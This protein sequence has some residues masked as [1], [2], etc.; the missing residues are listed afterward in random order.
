MSDVSG[1]M[2]PLHA[3]KDPIRCPDQ[4]VYC[5]APK[6]REVAF[7]VNKAIMRVAEG[8]SAN[9][10][11]KV[12]VPYCE[13]HGKQSK[14]FGYLLW[15]TY[16]I[17]TLV[18]GLPLGI[19]IL[20]QTAPLIVASTGEDW[21]GFVGG[22]V[23]AGLVAMIAGILAVRILKY[24]LGLLQP[25]L[26]DYNM[27]SALGIT[28][29]VVEPK[30][31]AELPAYT[32]DFTFANEEFAGVFETLNQMSEEEIAA[33]R[34]QLPSLT[35]L[36][37]AR[38]IEAEKQAKARQDEKIDALI[39]SLLSQKI[40]KTTTG[41][42]AAKELGEIGDARAVEPLIEALDD[43]QILVRT[44]AAKALGKIGDT[45][46]V[47]PLLETMPSEPAAEALGRIGDKRVL[48]L[49]IQVVEDPDRRVRE[50]AEAALDKIEAKTT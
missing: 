4:C 19:A 22:L 36:V 41:W 23:I 29:D 5:S 43:K 44:E 50:A 24:V 17:A 32:L 31:E 10:F 1:G 8:I 2:Q 3:L 16:I 12:I 38:E 21:I 6:S 7:N 11:Y 20:I 42:D 26:K 14:R 45:R 9:Y 35:A 18:I 15:S 27:D 47:E 28:V 39:E 46:A 49:L 33:A 25:T 48:G 37:Q 40:F 13:E 34:D 30:E